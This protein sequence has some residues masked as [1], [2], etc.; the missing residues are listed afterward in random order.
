MGKSCYRTRTEAGEG[1][2]DFLKTYIL[3]KLRVLLK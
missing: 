3:G 2:S 1:G